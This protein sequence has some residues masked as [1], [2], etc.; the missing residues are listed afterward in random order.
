MW[1][2][3]NLLIYLLVDGPLNYF[4]IGVFFFAIMNNSATNIHIQVFVGIYASM[5][6]R[7]ILGVD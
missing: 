2:Y 4:Q 7:Q 1:I 6:F 5:S 3:Q